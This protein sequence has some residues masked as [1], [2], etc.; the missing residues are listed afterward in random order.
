MTTSVR[1]LRRTCAFERQD[2]GIY[3][4]Y[5]LLDE[6][7]PAEATLFVSSNGF[8]AEGARRAGRTVCFIDRG[9][10]GPALD[11]DLQVRSLAELAEQIA[12]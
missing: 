3:D 7:A 11:P 8:D 9:G 5:A 10:A 12:P 4:I 2:V 1:L 6:I